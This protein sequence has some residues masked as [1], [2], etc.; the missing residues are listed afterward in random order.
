MNK[1][2]NII[3]KRNNF[4]NIKLDSI[5]TVKNENILETTIRMMKI[6]SDIDIIKDLI[7]PYIKLKNEEIL[8]EEESLEK[9]IF[10]K[11]F[12][13]K[14][15]HLENV[16][17]EYLRTVLLES[18]VDICDHNYLTSCKDYNDVYEKIKNNLYF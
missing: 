4:K 1:I 17:W 13:E 15:S 10:T 16:T 7:N 3:I 5:N 6:N 14:I 9:Q 12:F 2:N 8:T 18:G 11:L